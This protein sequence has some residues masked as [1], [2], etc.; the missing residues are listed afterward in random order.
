MAR[1][2]CLYNP[3]PEQL[4]AK[5]D[6]PNTRIT[7]LS[8]EYDVKAAK[9]A[10][11]TF[12]DSDDYTLELFEGLARK[13]MEDSN[14]TV[15]VITKTG[16]ARGIWPWKIGVRFQL[17]DGKLTYQDFG[18]WTLVLAFLAIS[19]RVALK[20]LW[21]LRLPKTQADVAKTVRAFC[22]GAFQKT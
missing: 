16:R 14:W 2:R 19:P 1:K 7:G 17:K 13:S 3:T 18:G 9:V 8:I 12:Y 4:Q 11:L 10:G 21:S 15:Y 5:I 20:T 22:M 6:D